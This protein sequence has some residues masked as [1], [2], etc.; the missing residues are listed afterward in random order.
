MGFFSRLF[1]RPAREGGARPTVG[2]PASA[3]LSILLQCFRDDNLSPAEDLSKAAPLLRGAGEDGS[4]AVAGLIRDLLDSRSPEIGW[5]LAAARSCVKTPRLQDAVRAV[6]AAPEL[7][8]GS[9]SASRFTPEIVGGGKIGW[10][11]SEHP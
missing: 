5:A 11:R 1:G 2:D 7:R 6:V 3:G 4:N 8:D 9:P 10:T